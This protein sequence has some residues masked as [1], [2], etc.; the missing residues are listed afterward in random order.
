MEWCFAKATFEA[1]INKNIS[2]AQGIAL[3]R[4]AWS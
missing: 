2:L 1:Q 4:D 3:S